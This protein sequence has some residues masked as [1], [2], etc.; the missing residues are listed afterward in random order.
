M[1]IYI[2]P[3][4]FPS[5]HIFQYP[6]HH[7]SLTA[8]VWA[9]D[10]G[11][12]ITTRVKENVGRVEVEIPVDGDS[13]VWREDRA[14]DLGFVTDVNAMN[15]H[16]EDVVGGYGFG[17]REKEK[18]KDKKGKKKKEEKWG[19]KARLRSELVPNATGYYSGI[20]RDG[21]SKPPK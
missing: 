15:G 11:K 8:P 1:P 7:R 4:L 17:G 6:L 12:R 19:D 13:V 10:R 16:G 20:V 5:L 18:E 9:K 21:E 2:S 14:R 3:A